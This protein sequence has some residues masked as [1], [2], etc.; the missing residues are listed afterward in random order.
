MEA[1]GQIQDGWEYH[2]QIRR[3]NYD[4]KVLVSSTD[5]CNELSNQDPFLIRD[6]AIL[7]LVLELFQSFFCSTWYLSIGPWADL[8]AQ[9]STFISSP[10]TACLFPYF[11]THSNTI[12]PSK[13]EATTATLLAWKRRFPSMAVCSNTNPSPTQFMQVLLV[14]CIMNLAKILL[15]SLYMQSLLYRFKSAQHRAYRK[16]EPC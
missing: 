1:G 12:F 7:L 11:W 4:V 6:Q 3:S 9:E 5:F 16:S 13:K 14:E 10:S 8:K 2:V 15:P